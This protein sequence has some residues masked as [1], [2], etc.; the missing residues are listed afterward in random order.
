MFLI[1]IAVQR[2]IEPLVNDLDNVFLYDIDDLERVVQ[3]NLRGR[4]QEAEQAELI[5]SEEVERMLVRLKSRD[6]APTIVSLQEQIEQLRLA[7][8]ARLRHKLCRITREQNEA[9]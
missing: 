5:V 7:E 9:I 3:G 6:V 1:D 4:L 2:N 8:L